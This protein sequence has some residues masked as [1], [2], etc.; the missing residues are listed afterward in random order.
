LQG[1]A[2]LLCIPFVF[3]ASACGQ[4]TPSANLATPS[5]ASNRPAGGP[6]PAQLRGDWLLPPAAGNAYL[7]SSGESCPTPLAAVTCMF[8]LTFT[9]TTYYFATN[10]PGRTSGGGDVVVNGTEMD[11]FN[12]QACGRTLPEGV[13]RYTWALA[14]GALHFAPLNQDTCPRAPVLANQTFNRPG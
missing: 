12:G 3:L 5:A 11:F 14:G 8:K 4:S 13:G 7:Q 2:A 10:A 1:I 6:V 9:A